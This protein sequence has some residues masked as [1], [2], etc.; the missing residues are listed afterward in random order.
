LDAWLQREKGI[1]LKDARRP[2]ILE[3]LQACQPASFALSCSRPPGA[4]ELERAKPAQQ[5]GGDGESGGGGGGDEDGGGAGA[6][7]LSQEEL[8]ERLWLACEVG[9]KQVAIE[10]IAEGADVTSSDQLGWTPLHYAASRNQIALLQL[11]LLN[12]AVNASAADDSGITALMVAA[13]SGFTLAVEY[14][15]VAGQ[16]R[17]AG[18]GD[19]NVREACEGFTA[20]HLAA[21]NNHAETAARLYLYGA[22]LAVTDFWGRDPETCARELGHE[23]TARRLQLMRHYDEE[24]DV[25]LRDLQRFIICIYVCVCIHIYIIYSCM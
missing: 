22:D 25:A 6:G 10:A 20:L 12:P 3:A 17:G 4:R 21:A 13:S 8:N 7:A 11:L 15:L 9:N 19:V 1:G 23:K 2:L 5:D 24:A 18:E 14:L 16:G